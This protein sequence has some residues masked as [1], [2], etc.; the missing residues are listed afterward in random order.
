MIDAVLM[1]YC[2]QNNHDV[3]ILFFWNM[4]LK[5]KN[6]SRIVLNVLIFAVIYLVKSRLSSTKSPHPVK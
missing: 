3:S 1:H 6:I 2:E 5:G 4:H